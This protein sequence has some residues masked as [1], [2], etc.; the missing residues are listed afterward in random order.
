MAWLR[1]R[2]LGARGRTQVRAAQR[3][4]LQYSASA[5]LPSIIGSGPRAPRPLIGRLSG[6][7]HADWPRRAGLALSASSRPWRPSH[8]R[9]SRKCSRAAFGAAGSSV[10]TLQPKCDGVC[11]GE[12]AIYPADY[13]KQAETHSY[14]SHCSQRRRQ[15]RGQKGWC[16]SARYQHRQYLRASAIN[17]KLR[18]E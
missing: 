12:V 9:S 11:W 10:P 8:P 3:P 14:G 6:G 1:S 4:W 17:P 5:S 7:V 13:R 2:A 16:G 18:A 15:A